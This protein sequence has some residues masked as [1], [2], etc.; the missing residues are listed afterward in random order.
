MEQRRTLWGRRAGGAEEDLLED[1]S[2]RSRGGPPQNLSVL[3]PEA[4]TISQGHPLERPHV[5]VP[6]D[7]PNMSTDTSISL[8]LPAVVL[9]PAS[10]LPSGG[11]R[12][13]AAKTNYPAELCPTSQPKESGGC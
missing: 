9:P 4:Q 11:P 13:S 7:L 10:R 3:L 8:Q 12:H 5:G 2:R 1:E 6:A